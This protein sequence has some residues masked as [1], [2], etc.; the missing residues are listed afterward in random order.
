MRFIHEAVANASTTIATAY[1]AKL[2]RANPSPSAIPRS[3]LLKRHEPSD[4]RSVPRRYLYR[5]NITSLRPFRYR[6][7]REVA[8]SCYELRGTFFGN[9]SRLV[10]LIVVVPQASLAHPAMI[11]FAD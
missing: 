3:D 6:P 1:P 11:V 5:K 7:G 9:K 10:P 8:S 2:I 4:Q